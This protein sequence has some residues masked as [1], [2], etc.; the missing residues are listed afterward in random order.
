MQPLRDQ[1]VDRDSII[2]IMFKH[3]ETPTSRR[4]KGRVK[5][6]SS[7]LYVEVRDY[8]LKTEWSDP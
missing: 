3:H 5:Q 7:L 6:L 2:M 4:A 1:E 8:L